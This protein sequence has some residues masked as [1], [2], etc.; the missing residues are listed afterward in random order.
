L[1]APTAA[2][3]SSQTTP[4]S[5]SRP[6]DVSHPVSGTVP[7]PEDDEVSVNPRAVGE[8]H[9]LDLVDAFEAGNAYPQSHVDAGATV[10]AGEHSAYVGSEATH[11]QRR[12]RLDNRHLRTKLEGR[13]GDLRTNEAAPDDDQ[14][15]AGAAAGAKAGGVRGG[16]EHVHARHR[17]QSRQQARRRT[18]CDD[19]AVEGESSASVH[20]DAPTVK[21]EVDGPPADQLD[22]ELAQLGG[23]QQRRS[24]RRRVGQERLGQRRPIGCNPVRRTRLVS[25]Q[26]ELVG[27]ATTPQSLNGPDS[28]ERSPTTTRRI[29][30][31]TEMARSGQLSA[32]S[33]A[34]PSSSRGTGSATTIACP[35]RSSR[36]KTSGALMWQTPCP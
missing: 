30:Q 36:S 18:G 25:Y 29:G 21:V 3:R 24:G 28:A 10:H 9:R 13:P 23:R 11:H 34:S 1:S 33:C 5:R 12:Q 4:S 27:K 32:P 22:P 31:W 35:S 2:K 8:A 6:E 20:R 17:L 14:A 19:E 16:A 7:Q 15:S 26:D